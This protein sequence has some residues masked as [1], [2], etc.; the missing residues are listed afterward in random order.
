MIWVI[1]VI[2]FG[3]MPNFGQS[4][5]IY[6]IKIPFPGDCFHNSLVAQWWIDGLINGLIESQ[7][8]ENVLWIMKNIS[9][10]TGVS[11]WKLIGMISVGLFHIYKNRGHHKFITTS[12]VSRVKYDLH[13]GICLIAI[14]ALTDFVITFQS[15]ELKRARNPIHSLSAYWQRPTVLHCM[16]PVKR[17]KSNKGRTLDHHMAF[18]EASCQ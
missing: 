3:L 4:Y 17:F 9:N 12:I 1:W 10:I 18:I 16:V 13:L 8:A 2:E 7:W 15:I 14:E 5:R 11:L 6:G